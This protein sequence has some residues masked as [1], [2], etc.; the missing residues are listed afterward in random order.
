MESSYGRVL[1]AEEF[2]QVAVVVHGAAA[3][4]PAVLLHPGLRLLRAAV[5]GGVSARERVALTPKR[6]PL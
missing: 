3:V 5:G 4:G 1:A 2:V 6:R